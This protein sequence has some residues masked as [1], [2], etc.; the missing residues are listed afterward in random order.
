MGRIFSWSSSADRKATRAKVSLFKSKPSHLEANS[1]PQKNKHIFVGRRCLQK[2]VSTHSQINHR[3][4]EI[5]QRPVCHSPLEWRA[6]SRSWPS[7]S[8][9]LV[10]WRSPA[11][12]P[13]GPRK[14]KKN[15][16]HNLQQWL[17]YCDRY[18]FINSNTFIMYIYIYRDTPT[19]IFW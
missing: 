11:P 2:M 13:A 8:D 18:V 4:R 1:C 17:I 9:L 7:K 19:I 15:G 14:T 10:S 12:G 5:N 6:G 16:C 3:N